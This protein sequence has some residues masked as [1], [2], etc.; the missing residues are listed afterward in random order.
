MLDLTLE[1]AKGV[2]MRKPTFNT[3]IL[4][5]WMLLSSCGPGSEG[6]SP[7]LKMP[8]PDGA[9]DVRSPL[10]YSALDFGSDRATPSLLSVI[11]WAEGTGNCYNYSFSY[12]PFASFAAH[13]GISYC[14]GDYC[15]T[16]AGRYQFLKA[17][18]ERLAIK[19]SFPSFDPLYQDAG[20]IA[21]IEEKQ[22]NDYAAPYDYP[23]FKRAMM[24]LGPV[25][26]S[27]PGAP[28]GQPTRSIEDAWQRYQKFLQDP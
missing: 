1:L 22:I 18:W 26:A 16:A 25:W 8:G 9:C 15:S 11:A 24:I 27:L 12:Q 7:L 17:T 10:R 4:L 19:R 5:C 3:I 20:A 28:Y 6:P 13:P 2:R 21:L 23:R 14:S